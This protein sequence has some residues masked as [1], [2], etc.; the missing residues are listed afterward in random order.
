[1]INGI[2]RKHGKSAAQVIL[3]WDIQHGLVTIPRSKTP[4]HIRENF[5]I[6]D[7]VLDDGDMKAIDAL[8]R[9]QGIWRN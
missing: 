7:F 4:A 6:T 1:M 2:A 5:G 3:R 8:D 9:D